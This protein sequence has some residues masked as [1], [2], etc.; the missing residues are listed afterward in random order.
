MV[1][2]SLTCTKIMNKGPHFT[3]SMKTEIIQ[4]LTPSIRQYWL[5]FVI[6]VLSIFFAFKKFGVHTVTG[7]SVLSISGSLLMY[8]ILSVYTT[9]YLI[10]HQGIFI[11]K[12]PFSRRLREIP[13]RDITNIFIKQRGMQRWFR[14]GNLTITTEQASRVLKGVKNPHKIK[15]LINKEKASEHER[16]T[17][18]RKIL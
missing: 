6:L 10:T 5:I 9:K 17:L 2:S 12:G 18:L 1:F 4:S 16:R 8:S 14:I 3:K 15:E 13:Y 7:L 11:R